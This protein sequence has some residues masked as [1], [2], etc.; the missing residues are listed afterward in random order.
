MTYLEVAFNYQTLPGE[1]ELR[2]IDNMR[3]VY[4]IQRVKFN[5][6]E[7]TVR[8]LYDA[9]RMKQDAVA[10]MLRQAGIDVREPMALA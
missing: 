4:G 2:A 6:K 3:E 9:S 1:N 5:E 10:K 8:V 7:K